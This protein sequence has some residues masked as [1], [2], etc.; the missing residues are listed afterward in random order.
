MPAKL[1]IYYCI[2]SAHCTTVVSNALNSAAFSA[3]LLLCVTSS[4]YYVV[5]VKCIRT[6]RR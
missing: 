1:I 6:E 5:T 4:K 3:H 2:F